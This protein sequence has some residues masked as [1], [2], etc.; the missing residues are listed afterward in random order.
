MWRK[1][2]LLVG[3]LTALLATAAFVVAGGARKS[4][5]EVSE[6]VLVSG[7]EPYLPHVEPHLAADPENPKHLVAVTMAF[8]NPEERPTVTTFT[9]LDGGQTWERVKLPGLEDFSV[10]DPWVAFGRGGRVYVTCLPRS[11]LLVSRSSDGGRTW[12]APV[13]VP[14]G[15]GGSYDHP[16][17]AADSTESKYAGRVY[18]NA[19]Q[20]LKTKGGR[21]IS[22]ISVSRSIDGGQVF[23]DP[24]QIL[25][26]DFNNESGNLVVLSDG[27]LV[28]PF[29]EF[30]K[31]GGE[32][33]AAP[34]LWVAFS[35]DGG[36]SL[37]NPHLV[38][39][40]YRGKLPHVAVDGSKG[41]YR[42]RLYLVWAGDSGRIDFS[43]SKEKGESWSQPTTIDQSPDKVARGKTPIIAVNKD[44]VIGVAWH[45]R[46]RDPAGKCSEVFFSA[47]FDGGMTFLPSVPVST[48]RSCPDAPGN[49][50]PVRNGSTVGDE[51]PTGGDYMGLA[52]AADGL[53][54]VVWSDSRTGVYQS[55]TATVRVI[56]K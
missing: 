54:H 27:T 26:N 46:R 25:P 14:R 30:Q 44:G 21:S 52:A 10:W 37:S 38:T 40:F 34:R 7:D 35:S 55:W 53:F 24:V 39:E 32:P 43:L 17:I 28:V 41:P 12:S 8:T 11:L 6:N 1:I 5:I 4:R 49:S 3:V 45:D 42:D 29:V 20:S 36:A 22:S 19:S 47:S 33:L 2:L 15:S 18:V 13:P 50:F 51:W 31:A 9:T 23:S 56:S 48:A 16:I